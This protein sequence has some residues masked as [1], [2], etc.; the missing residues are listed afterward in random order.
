MEKNKYKGQFDPKCVDSWNSFEIF[1]H[2]TATRPEYHSLTPEP[3][4]SQQTGS[5]SSNFASFV[6]EHSAT[7]IE[8]GK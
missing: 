4:F 8:L 6:I 2:V 3:Y 7:E 5:I 1:T